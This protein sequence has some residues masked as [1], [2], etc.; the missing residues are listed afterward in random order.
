MAPKNLITYHVIAGACPAWSIPPLLRSPFLNQA[1]STFSF[2]ELNNKDSF[3]LVFNIDSGKKFYFN[4]LKL[5]LPDD[6]N[7]NDFEKIEK[8]F[9]KLKNETYSLDKIN[10]ILDEIDKIASLR[11]Y[12]FINAEVEEKFID[13]N[14]INFVFNIIDSEKLFSN[15]YNGALRILSLLLRS[16]LPLS[17]HLRLV[18]SA[19]WFI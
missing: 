13:D 16:V 17:L 11:L 15:I 3:K 10:L 8:I 7:K 2:A 14:K 4:N 9:S 12:D 18:L 19:L 6:Y 5:S 1:A